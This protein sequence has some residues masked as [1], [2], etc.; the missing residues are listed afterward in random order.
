MST[1]AVELEAPDVRDVT[2]TT[3]TLS[4]DLSDDRTISVP[5]EWFLGFFT[6]VRR[7]EKIGV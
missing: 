2:V 3:D 6:P 5:L 1:S 7:R 4:V